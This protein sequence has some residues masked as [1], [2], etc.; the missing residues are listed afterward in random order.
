MYA[1]ARSVFDHARSDLDQALT[2]HC[3]LSLGQRAGLGDG[4]A[5]AMHKPERGG[6]QNKPNLVGSCV[7]ARHELRLVQFDQ[8]RW[9]MGS[10][11]SRKRSVFQQTVVQ[12]CIVHLI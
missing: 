6:V 2:Y 10:W 12:T 11:V 9:S 1:N 4:G 5:H 8:V 7:M 3:E